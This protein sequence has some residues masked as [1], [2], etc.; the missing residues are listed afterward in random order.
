MG[1]MGEN[2]PN[3]DRTDVYDEIINN[4]IKVLNREIKCYDEAIKTLRT[5]VAEA[6]K[7]NNSESYYGY[8][9]ELKHYA[10]QRND[11]LNQIESLTKNKKAKAWFIN[12][13]KD[14][15]LNF[16]GEQEDLGAGGKFK[17]FAKRDIV[18][19]KNI[20]DKE[21]QDILSEFSGEL[22]DRELSG[23]MASILG[24]RVGV[25][26]KTSSPWVSINVKGVSKLSDAEYNKCLDMIVGPDNLRNNQNAVA[27]T[28][29]I[30]KQA[31]EEEIM[32][33]ESAISESNATKGD[34]KGT[35][36][37]IAHIAP[38]LTTAL[39]PLIMLAAYNFN[40][41]N[42][43]GSI[44]AGIMSIG[45]GVAVSV[46]AK[47]APKLYNFFTDID[48]KNSEYN[49][50]LLKDKLDQIENGEISPEVLNKLSEIISDS[51]NSAQ[52]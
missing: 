6:K 52:M 48:N 5:F 25:Q 27:T 21:V 1:N 13:L 16:S 15:Y 44:K 17:S 41:Y 29:R 51:V 42:L 20:T 31:I 9:A 24:N 8:S 35:G 23:A 3:F 34:I 49:I 11:T 40:G 26:G 37:D 2:R 28:A 7:D 45:V 46:L 39:T 18:E 47:V 50:K 22:M 38:V 12:M 30:A 32:A 36:D 19:R 4:W 10:E 14:A 33:N 43:P